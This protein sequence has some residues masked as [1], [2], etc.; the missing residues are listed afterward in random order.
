MFVGLPEG[1]SDASIV[2]TLARLGLPLRPFDPKDRKISPSAVV[3]YTH[4][5][6]SVSRYLRVL[7]TLKNEPFFTFASPCFSGP[8]GEWKTYADEIVV[9]TGLSEPEL[10][11]LVKNYGVKI[12]KADPY[13]PGV[14]LLKVI[15][16]KGEITPVTAANA[17]YETGRFVYAEPNFMRQNK[18]ETNDPYFNQQ[19]ALKNAG[20]SSV[21]QGGSV[22]GADIAIEEAWTLTTGSPNIKV[23]I[24]D[25]GVDFNH[26]DLP[27]V[28]PGFDPGGNSL[29]GEPVDPYGDVHGTPCAGIVA[30]QIDNNVDIAGIAPQCKILP[31]YLIGSASMTDDYEVA[32][33]FNWCRV[34]GQADVLSNSWRVYDV[35]GTA[36]YD[37]ITLCATQGRNGL[38]CVILGGAG[39]E[40]QPVIGFPANHPYVIAVGG[41]SPCD[42]R[43]SYTSCDESGWGAC[44]GPNLDFVAPAEHI[45][46][47]DNVDDAGY[48]P[49]NVTLFGG[50]SAACPIAAGVAAL[51]LSLD[52][53]LTREQVKRALVRGCEKVGGYVYA[54]N[55]AHPLSSWNNEMG[56]GRL[57]AKNTLDIVMGGVPFCEG[58]VT[59]N[60]TNGSV[61]DGS[62][63]INYQPLSDC[64]WLIQPFG[65][66]QITINFT[67]LETELGQDIVRVYSGNTTANLVGEYSGSNLPPTL[68]INNSAALICF[69][70]DDDDVV[71]QGFSL[72]YTSNGIPDYCSGHVNYTAASGSFC[73]GSPVMNYAGSAYCTFRI[74]PPAGTTAI[75]INFTEFDVIPGW[76]DGGDYLLVY[77]GANSSGQLIG[78]FNNNNVPDEVVVIGNA[79]YLVFVSDEWETG[80]GW[81]LNYQAI[82]DPVYCLGTQT[83]STVSGTLTDGSGANNYYD[84]AACCWRIRPA[85]VQ[86]GVLELNFT[87][88]QLANEDTLYVYDGPND[89]APLLGAFTGNDLP[90]TFF[91]SNRVLFLCLN[92][93]PGQT[94]QGFAADW[95]LRYCIAQQNLSAPTGN[96][97]DGSGWE[98]Y[99]PGTDCCWLIDAGDGE[100]ELVFKFENFAT[101][102]GDDYIVVYDGETS[103]APV[104][105]TFSGY[106]DW[107]P[108]SLFPTS[109]RFLVCF[110]SDDDQIVEDGFRARWYRQ[111]CSG[112]TTLTDV[113][114]T[115]CDGSGSYFYAP[116]TECSWL[117][118]V[119]GATHV[120][121]EFTEFELEAGGWGG[122]Q[123]SIYNDA[124]GANA[125]LYTFS[126][127][128]APLGPIAVL[129]NVV[130]VR[131]SVPDWG[132]G[133]AG[134]CINYSA[135]FDPVFCLGTQ[136]LN[137]NSGT[138]SDGSGNENYLDNSNC[139]WYISPWAWEGQMQ[140]TFTEFDL[141]PGDFVTVWGGNPQW[142]GA[143][144]LGTFSGNE[145]PPII[146][147]PATELYICFTSNESGTAGGFS[148]DY[149]L[150]V[151]MYCSPTTTLFN[152]S[153]EV[154][155]G[156]GDAFYYNNTNCSWL[157]SPEN[158]TQIT[159]RFTEFA[160]ENFYDYVRIYRGNQALPLNLLYEYTG[161]LNTPFEITVPYGQALVVFTTDGSVNEQGWCFTYTSDGTA[162]TCSGEQTLTATTAA[163]CDGSGPE[164]YSNNLDCRWKIVPLGNPVSIRLRFDEFDLAPADKVLIFASDSPNENPIAAF[165]SE[166]LPVEL[167]IENSAAYVQFLTNETNTAAGWCAQYEAVFVVPGCIGAAEPMTASSG[168]FSD[169]SGE[170]DYANNLFCTWTIRPS[171]PHT[172]IVLRFNAFATEENKDLVRV[173]DGPNQQST[174]LA[175]LSG[176]PSVP[177]EIVGT[178]QEMLVT[179][180]SDAT[181]VAAGWDAEYYILNEPSRCSG[182]QTLNTTSGEFSDGSGAENYGV[183]SE[184]YWLIQPP[185]GPQIELEFT[186]FELEN[187]ADFV[188]IY[189]GVSTQSPLLA[190]H[191]GANLPPKR[192]YKSPILVGFR[193][194][195][196]NNFAGFSAQYAA[197]VSR[198]NALNPIF[199]VYPNPNRGSF[200]IQTALPAH[201]T[202]TDAKGAVV[203]T[204]QVEGLTETTL[205]KPGIYALTFQAGT[206]VET[207]KITVV[208]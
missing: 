193:T 204:L 172:N 138:I 48:G 108:P 67:E 157:V 14:W 59:L 177:L 109:N 206:R 163:F 16:P 98:T 110:H 201:V 119:E 184:C 115:F 26:P 91:A 24:L 10:N 36:T 55:P 58:T 140:L 53:S 187:G 116:G 207:V 31:I 123:L 198:E 111:Y 186:E 66:T 205:E 94:G 44:Y 56:H 173:Y 2:Q 5:V 113:E 57:N 1:A 182:T 143:P 196:K 9:K 82:T 99:A 170:S 70:S 112:T 72:N 162:P 40:D 155:D 27:G 76:G 46:S 62:G 65:A 126:N 142:G 95:T 121:L 47:L 50:T 197:L 130:L 146:N 92:S 125:P 191:T 87:Q 145:L 103:S 28:L 33:A 8:M 93:N 159:I 128:Q 6:S 171:A 175:T 80:A 77:R 192:T 78:Q 104:L 190:T 83:F 137:E 100:G 20:A 169:G 81:C 107:P 41:S 68:N 29:Q 167:I 79:A 168:V 188:R 166:N 179:F 208:K 61:S 203:R 183:N 141:A 63:P 96:I 200:V 4:N 131:F 136:T 144:L 19:W 52:P 88:F 101:E 152:P 129:G 156:S 180:T 185:G 17:L 30:A 71:G 42:E 73:D 160:T 132:S 195:G 18:P 120:T 97:S 32:T 117:I 15:D 106:S 25:Q 134:W 161:Y 64:C 89:N 199:G 124:A 11:G 135:S 114:G 86:E 69:S 139:C 174:L 165:N 202:V 37:A 149:Q 164:N 189:D 102:P 194:D 35:V 84:N 122:T 7:K 39:N 148:A 105:G 34:E 85:N 176:T 147:A 49:E 23:A 127:W 51:A 75:R 38:G 60:T 154:C 150:V 151:P 133:G 158:A 118:N 153:G 22:A 45:Y 21:P 74:Q 13:M 90:G 3:L 43:K 178:A 12:V 181:G 54:D